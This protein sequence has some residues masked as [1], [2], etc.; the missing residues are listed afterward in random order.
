MKEDKR[1]D[2]K[3]MINPGLTFT[4]N[5]TAATSFVSFFPI[6]NVLARARRACKA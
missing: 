1:S 6:S 5:E 4:F 2:G 3:Q